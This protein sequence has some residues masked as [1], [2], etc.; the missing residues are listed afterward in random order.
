METQGI[1]SNKPFCSYV[2]DSPAQASLLNHRDKVTIIL[3]IKV[4]ALSTYLKVS[5]K[6]L[7]CTLPQLFDY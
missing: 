4:E 5:T 7:H 1:P 6:L 2:I 3:T